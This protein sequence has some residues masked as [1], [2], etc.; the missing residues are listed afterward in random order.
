MYH[1]KDGLIQTLVSSLNKQVVSTYCVSGTVLGTRKARRLNPT[2]NLIMDFL[3]ETALMLLVNIQGRTTMA[4]RYYTKINPGSCLPGDDNVMETKRHLIINHRARSQCFC[5]LPPDLSV[6]RNATHGCCAS[7][8]GKRVCVYGMI[9]WRVGVG[10]VVRRE[11]QKYFHRRNT[12]PAP[13]MSHHYPY[14]IFS[15]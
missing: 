1:L 8:E 2:P 11:L 7:V 15:P 14:N 5:L 4:H 12:N 13:T 6:D 9:G 3:E 10:V